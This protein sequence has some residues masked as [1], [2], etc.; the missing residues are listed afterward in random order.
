MKKRLWLGMSGH[1]CRETGMS[2]VH[3]R[4]TS[5]SRVVV[6][7]TVT[8]RKSEHPLGSVLWGLGCA[9]SKWALLQEIFGQCPQS[10]RAQNGKHTEVLL[11]VDVAIFSVY[12]GVFGFPNLPSPFSVWNT[13]GLRERECG[14]GGPAFIEDLQLLLHST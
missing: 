9:V 14:R 2:L 8:T 6:P 11:M 5:V 13:H 7:A 12:T 10:Q 3:A 4:S 1:V